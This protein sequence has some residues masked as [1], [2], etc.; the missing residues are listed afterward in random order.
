MAPRKTKQALSKQTQHPILTP[1]QEKG[2][3][4]YWGI[5]EAHRAEVRAE[6]VQEIQNHPDFKQILQADQ[7]QQ[8]PEQERAAF[9]LQRRAVVEGDWEPYLQSLRI[10]G[11]HYARAGLGFRAW[12]QVVSSF[13]RLMQPYIL[14]AY[15]HS[16][17]QLL[18]A[19]EGI[20]K[21][22]EIG[23]GTIGDTYLE[24]K[25]QL[26]LEQEAAI[27]DSRER[28]RAEARFRGLLEAAPDAMVIVDETGKM[29]LVNSQTE[30]L[31]GY[32]REE[33]L[34]QNVDMLLPE[35]F[36][37]RHAVHRGEYYAAPSVRSMGE[38]LDL[39]GLCKDGSEF[40]VEVSLSPLETETGML[41]TAAVRDVSERKQSE[42]ALARERDLLS[43]LMDNIPD[44][45]YFKDTESRFTRINRAQAAVL[46]VQAPEDAEG[47]TDFE[48][49]PEKLARDFYKEEQE[50]IR[51][52]KPLVDR[53]ESNPTRQGKPRWF[54]ATK[55]PIKDQDG[56]VTSI[57]GISRDITER[58][59]AERKF[60]G[61]L[62]SAPDAVVVVN[63][64]GTIEIVNSQSEKLFGYDRS[65][66]LG[67]PIE[68][69]IPERFKEGHVAY[70]S[71]YVVQPVAR[72]MGTGLELYGRRSDGTEFP[73]E[74]S[75]SPLETEGGQLVTAAIRDVTDRMQ[76]EHEV[77][78]L[79]A[80][81][82]RRA[83]ELEVA[84]RELEAFSYSVSH[85]L[86]APLRTI[87]GF[88]QALLE[89][90]GDSLP[91]DAQNFLERVRHAAQRMAKLIDD[92]LELSRI[93]RL[94]VER[95]PIDVTALAESIAEELRQAEPVRKVTFEIAP[96]LKTHGDTQLLRIAMQNL[97]NNAW[98]F[99][100]KVDNATIQ[101]GHRGGKEPQVFFVRDNGA[102]FDMS[103]ASKLFG[104]F[105]RLH[106]VSEFPG[107]GI[108]LA[109]VQRIVIKHGGR[110]WAESVVNEGATFYFTLQPAEAP[111]R[112]N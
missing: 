55:V 36:R 52:G 41:V 57:V 69:L 19:L 59:L 11:Q 81:L 58:V 51:S 104:A 6:L 35:R 101:V 64:E 46:G 70:R 40:P 33:L 53:I 87:D 97:M 25:Q 61:L 95:Q 34:G 74:I 38:N 56:R 60:R 109:T 20:D 54:S 75:L 105:Q 112:R 93:S 88:S 43:A 3:R 14:D 63:H 90:Y 78:E 24:I 2:L 37:A 47:K 86:R 13:R 18:S 102:G 32:S 22:I 9:E 110:I 83:T 15:R 7:S 10:Q 44:S 29:V 106:A 8:T 45:I 17:D 99:T 103:Y 31:F 80:T 26:I 12:F 21:F 4:D 89:D 30:T 98:K 108:G 50:I 91:G 28:Q 76:S 16:P 42:E 66:L 49:Q 107:T 71:N 39:F 79:N 100:S 96:Q 85:D 111:W 73:V 62:E 5:Y 48:F 68:M 84:N 65:E 23:L 72:P 77:Q 67:K 27:K 82:Q 94:P 92:L 1:E